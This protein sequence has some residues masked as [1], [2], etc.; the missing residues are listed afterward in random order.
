[1]R[2]AHGKLICGQCT[3]APIRKEL[4]RSSVPGFVF[5]PNMTICRS[6]TP[7]CGNSEKRL[8][9]AHSLREI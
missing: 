7:V 5:R 9:V 6:D 2:K 1:M 3:D 8:M 4:A